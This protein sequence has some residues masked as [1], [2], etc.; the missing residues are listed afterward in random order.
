MVK[1]YSELF[2]ISSS[3]LNR[4]GA[5]DGIY[6]IDSLLHIDPSL[7]R[8]CTIPELLSSNDMLDSYFN[9][10]LKLIKS[11]KSKNDTLFKEAIKRLTFPEINEISLGFS[12]NKSSGNGIGPKLA[13]KLA[14]TA[15]EIVSAGIED[16]VIFELVGLLEEGIGPDRISDMVV[17]IILPNLLSFTNRVVTK[18]QIP[19]RL[20]K[21]RG[22]KYHLPY[23]IEDDRNIILLPKEILR[24]LPVAYDWDDIDRICSYNDDLRRT[25]NKLIGK[26]WKKAI[27]ELRKED[28]RNRLLR[29]PEALRDLIKQYK[30]KKLLGYDFIQDNKGILRWYD[31]AF[32]TTQSIP[33][34]ID[35]PENPLP[36]DILNL[37]IQIC[38]QFKKLIEE[39]G[40][41]RLLYENPTKKHHE[42]YPQ[43]LFF[44]IADMYCYIN[45]IDINR[46]PNNGKGPV[47]FKYSR[48]YQ[49]KVNVEIKYASNP[50][51]IDGYINQLPAYNTAEKTDHSVYL[52]IRTTDS[53]KKIKELLEIRHSSITDGERTPEIII[54]DGRWQRTASKLKK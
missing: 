39:N 13:E 21:I 32:S 47:D 19:T 6:G 7:L 22:E 18:L 27:K 4:E 14:I 38:I 25:F 49:S 52:V 33:F 35:F 31:D 37:V 24:D 46:E 9:N 54:I 10:I 1:K 15:S 2:G 50:N 17:Q 20:V 34:K 12:K 29:N 48:G 23:F 53:E 40:L 11:S 30:N 5:F 51:L 45:N 44:G 28:L 8:Q 36:Q 3:D 42:R 26:N 16:P 43:L 41:F